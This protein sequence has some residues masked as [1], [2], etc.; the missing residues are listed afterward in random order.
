MCFIRLKD[1]WKAEKCA[2]QWFEEIGRGFWGTS[3][4]HCCQMILLSMFIFWSRIPTKKKANSLSRSL[5]YFPVENINYWA[6]LI[7]CSEAWTYTSLSNLRQ[8]WTTLKVGQFLGSA[9][10]WVVLW[11]L[12]WADWGLWNSTQVSVNHHSLQFCLWDSERT[13]LSSPWIR[14][15]PFTSC[16]PSILCG[17]LM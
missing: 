5:F 14:I 11:W 6:S 15:F 7:T 17:I 10:N 4:Y 16:S 8:T 1:P 9:L 13:P 12:Q 3:C 2:R